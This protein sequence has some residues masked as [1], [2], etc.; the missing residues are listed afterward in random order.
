MVNVCLAVFASLIQ[1][2]EG[3][4][5]TWWPPASHFPSQPSSN[6]KNV[7]LLAENGKSTLQQQQKLLYVLLAFLKFL[8]SPLSSNRYMFLRNVLFFF[9]ICYTLV[10]TI[11]DIF[12]MMICKMEDYHLPVRFCSWINHL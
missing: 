11:R 3:R 9:F 12:M 10:A 5:S 2:I 7:L 8:I 6:S 4:L 1:L